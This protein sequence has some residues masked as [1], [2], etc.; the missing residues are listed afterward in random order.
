MLVTESLVKE[1]LHSFFSKAKIA[2]DF[3]YVIR[4][5]LHMH[6]QINVNLLIFLQHK[7]SRFSV[8]MSL[9][10]ILFLLNGWRRT[11][12][13]VPFQLFLKAIHI[14]FSAN[15]KDCTRSSSSHVYFDMIHFA[16]QGRF[17]FLH[18]GFSEF[19]AI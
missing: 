18:H 3:R 11:V 13:L 7:I 8:G 10:N 5:M 17:L 19:W 2:A 12:F 4:F 9:F 14:A 15:F 6:K 16:Q 1:L